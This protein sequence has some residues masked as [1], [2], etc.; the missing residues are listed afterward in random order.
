VTPTKLEILLRRG[1]LWE[2]YKTLSRCTQKMIE[3]DKSRGVKNLE[4][5]PKRPRGGG[6]KSTPIKARDVG[7]K[8][9]GKAGG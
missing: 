2:W 7:L 9:A 4:K 8:K 5:I 6:K 3:E 1:L